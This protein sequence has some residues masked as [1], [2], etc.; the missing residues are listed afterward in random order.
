[1]IGKMFKKGGNPGM[2]ESPPGKI[3]SGVGDSIKQELFR[4]KF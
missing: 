4:T 2:G 3:S 1:M